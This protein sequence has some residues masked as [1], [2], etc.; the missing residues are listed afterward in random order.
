[1]GGFTTNRKPYAAVNEILRQGQKDFIGESGPADRAGPHRRELFKP[2][3]E[4]GL[5][6]TAVVYAPA[7]AFRFHD[8][9][10]MARSYAVAPNS[11]CLEKGVDWRSQ[12][13]KDNKADGALVH[14][15]RVCKAWS[16]Y[17]PEMQRRWQ[18]ELGIP[19]CRL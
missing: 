5:N 11:V 17:M 14:Y 8:V 6:V 2:L 15:N 7:F 19:R 9:D 10:G 13:C 3:K 16:G 4:N 1:M 18:N 12:L